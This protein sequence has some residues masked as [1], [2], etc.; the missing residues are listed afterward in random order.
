MFQVVVWLVFLVSILAAG[1]GYWLQQRD[2]PIGVPM[3][4][5]ALVCAFFSFGFV[6]GNLL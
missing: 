6:A 1:G 3:T 4:V 2:H 5:G